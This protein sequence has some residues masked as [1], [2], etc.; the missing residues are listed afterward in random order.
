[1]NLMELLCG[2]SLDST[3]GSLKEKLLRKGQ[4]THTNQL[5]TSQLPNQ[6]KLVL[7]THTYI[8]IYSLINSVP[9][10]ATDYPINSQSI[11]YLSN[12]L[13]NQLT[14]KSASVD[15]HCKSHCKSHSLT[16]HITSSPTSSLII[17]SP[18]QFR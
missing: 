7:H 14:K 17:P 8:F 16:H 12:Q 10:K 5:T 3:S 11:H 4:I 15:S 1:M 13:R 6:N 9:Q 18:H 2:N